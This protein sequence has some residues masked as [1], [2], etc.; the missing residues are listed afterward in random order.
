M[1]GA[2]LL[3]GAVLVTAAAALLGVWDSPLV[4]VN[5]HSTTELRNVV[6]SG[7]GFTET[8]ERLGPGESREVTVR[9][10]GE[11]S[12]DIAFDAAG[13]RVH[14]KGDTYIEAAGGYRVEMDVA[15]D[16]SVRVRHPGTAR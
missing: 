2:G 10:R 12:V 8:L 9:P 6:L 7:R 14:V 16:L 3:A 1:L 15:P 5:N 11:S 4:R 13:R